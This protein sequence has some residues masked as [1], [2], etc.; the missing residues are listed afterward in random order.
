[1]EKDHA[2]TSLAGRVLE[3]THLVA[4]VL[5]ICCHVRCHVGTDHVRS[6]EV[7]A[8]GC[9]WSFLS[10]LVAVLCL[11]LANKDHPALQN[12]CL[13]VEVIFVAISEVMV[14]EVKVVQDQGVMY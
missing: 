4:R 8:P 10:H 12:V 9:S 6:H 11:D 2:V 1:M 13:I 7:K 3:E 14:P 5:V